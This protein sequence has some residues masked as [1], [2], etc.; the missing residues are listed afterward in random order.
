MVTKP[1]TS[2]VVG[3]GGGPNFSE[4]VHSGLAMCG[5]KYSDWPSKLGVSRLNPG[6][7]VLPGHK[8]CEV[9]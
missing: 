4:L 8:G 1:A 9:E 2:V 7:S 3:S 5:A 6:I